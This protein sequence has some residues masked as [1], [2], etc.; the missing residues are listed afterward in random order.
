MPY[1]CTENRVV[2]DGVYILVG[3]NTMKR[4]MNSILENST[5][6]AM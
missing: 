3:K 6:A 5:V 1:I 2:K 4:K